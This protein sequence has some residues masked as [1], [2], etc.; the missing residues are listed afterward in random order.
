M[1]YLIRIIFNG[2]FVKKSL[3]LLQELLEKTTFSEA[4][5]QKQLLEM[6]KLKQACMPLFVKHSQ[7]YGGH[8]E[9][10]F[11]RQPKIL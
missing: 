7:T 10:I 3:L 8:L 9:R 2:K 11:G 5:N 1:F 4:K 6:P